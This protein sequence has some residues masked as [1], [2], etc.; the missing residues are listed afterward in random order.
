MIK[1]MEI[2]GVNNEFT[3]QFSL[4]YIKYIVVDILDNKHYLTI[5]S[6]LP[7]CIVIIPKEKIYNYGLSNNKFKNLTDNIL[8]SNLNKE[9]LPN[10]I[11][12]KD[13][14]YEDEKKS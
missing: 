11:L 7:K 5:T 14:Y 13:L 12:I 4:K 8:E 1:E 9:P 2:Y 3:L 10:Y 6:M